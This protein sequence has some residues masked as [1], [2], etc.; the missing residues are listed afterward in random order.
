[1]PHFAVIATIFTWLLIFILDAQPVISLEVRALPKDQLTQ[2]AETYRAVLNGLGCR[3]FAEN[4]GLN[5]GKLVF[6]FRPP[7]GATPSTLAEELQKYVPAE[8]RGETDWSVE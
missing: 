5:K 4:R 6:I 8:L 2:A 3:M 1:L 7:R